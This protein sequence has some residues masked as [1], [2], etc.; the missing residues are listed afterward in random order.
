MQDK[1][2]E[3][4]RPTRYWWTLLALMVLFRI[5]GNAANR[6]LYPFLTVIQSGLDLS[7]EEL[8]QALSW[9][10]IAPLIAIPLM[11]QVEGRGARWGVGLGWLL[12]TL[13]WMAVGFWPQAE[14]FVLAVVAVLVGKIVADASLQDWISQQVPYRYRGRPLVF[15]E[16]GWSLSFFLVMP[17]LAWVTERTSWRGLVLAVAGLMAVVGFWMYRALPAPPG[18]NPRLLALPRPSPVSLLRALRGL[19][20]ALRLR[21][22]AG[23]W[24]GFASLVANELVGLVFGDWLYRT[25]G[26]AVQGLGIAAMAIGLGEL[27]GELAALG[28]VDFLGK[29]RAVA[30]GLVLNTLVVLLLPSLGKWG[31]P[32]AFTGLALFFLTFEFALV[33]SIPIISQVWPRHRGVL[34]AAY[35]VALVWGRSAASAL[36]SWVYPTWGM[37]GSG[38]VAAVWNGLALLGLWGISRWWE[39]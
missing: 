1:A 11:F 15:I 26:L 24:L 32:W 28:V 2:Q 18:K 33:S 21:V 12:M 31:V 38:L 17:W 22:L 10:L 13:P 39:E 35:A 19:P 20:V 27:L 5:G 37:A 16:L 23:L 14:L 36:T 3:V 34:M 7:L 8:S 25:H 9:R 6:F 29:T 30:L 4:W